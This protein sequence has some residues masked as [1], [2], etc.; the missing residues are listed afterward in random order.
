TALIKKKS[1][2]ATVPS[3]ASKERRIEGKKQLS[4]IKE[5]RRRLRPGNY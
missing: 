4:V 1:R 3:K 2:I 5:T